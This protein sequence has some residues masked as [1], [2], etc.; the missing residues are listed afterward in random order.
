ML[1]IS[2]K[3][4]QGLGNQL[5]ILFTAL[6]LSSTNK[7][8]LV[9]ENYK[10][11]VGR[12][13][14]TLKN[15]LIFENK[16]TL[17]NF[18]Y[19]EYFEPLFFEKK[20]KSYISLFDKNIFNL[21]FSKNIKLNGLF[22]SEKYIQIQKEYI[23]KNHV[24]F[25]SY[26]KNIDK[27]ICVINVRGGE[28]KRHKQL[29]LPMSYWL[30]AIS[31]M[32]QKV[33]NIKFIVV[34][35]DGN[36]AKKLFPE[37]PIISHSIAEC[38]SVLQ[39]AQY[40]ILSNSSFSFFPIFFSQIKNPIIIAPYLWARFYNKEDLWCSPVNFY[41]GWTWINQRG[42]IISNKRCLESVKNTNEYF[43]KN[44]SDVSK[45]FHSAQLTHLDII[46]I[47][48]KKKIKKLLNYLF[49]YVF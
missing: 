16:N 47:I 43:L 13:F 2:F 20:L 3:Y 4:G 17:K 41:S 26:K 9:I 11:F 5:W 37:Y 34:T 25:S 33:S 38:F 23:L 30:N 42:Q 44:F 35:D 22:Q 21:D 27:N 48:F 32:K 8:K 6:S 24:T 28:Y 1:L 15:I 36:Y 29:I 45:K 10:Y 7:K 39:M 40:L 14:I 31:I 18:N 46:K 12:D 19:V 49:P